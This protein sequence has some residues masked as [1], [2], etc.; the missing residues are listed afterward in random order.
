MN[1]P[2]SM[3]DLYGKYEIPDTILKMIERQERSQDSED[4]GLFILKDD[5]RRYM[6]TPIDSIPFATIRVDGIHY[7]FLTEF[8]AVED[9][10]EAPIIC[11][12]PMD[13]GL[14][15]RYAGNN[16]AQ[17]LEVYCADDGIFINH[18]ED[19]EDYIRYVQ[20]REEEEQQQPNEGD[21]KLP[22]EYFE[23]RKARIDSFRADFQLKKIERSQLW[24]ELESIRAL[25]RS[26]MILET[27]N[28]LGVLPI[29][30]QNEGVGENSH[31]RLHWQ[32][33]GG[34]SASNELAEAQKFVE[35]A[36]L[37]SRIGFVRDAQQYYMFQCI[38]WRNWMIE[39]LVL[40]G[41]ETEAKNL[42]LSYPTEQYMPVTDTLSTYIYLEWSS[43]DEGENK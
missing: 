17:F 3:R 6:S 28:G 5:D 19:E 27:V 2:S 37:E 30:K 11:V 21:F 14:E 24:K 16:L 40:W 29:D 23:E 26:K 32:S 39:Q 31:T 22:P 8:G 7:A 42:Q 33:D 38:E 43:S 12:S 10:N 35:A 20:Q 41:Y 15:I 4:I 25:R 36:S 1:I 13:F 34:N 18:F 9:L